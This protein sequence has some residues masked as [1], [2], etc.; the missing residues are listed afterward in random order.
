MS[1]STFEVIQSELASRKEDIKPS[2]V[3]LFS[4]PLRSAINFAVRLGNFSLTAFSK[5]L[6]LTRAESKQIADILVER[7][8]FTVQPN[9]TDEEIFYKARL[10][11]PARSVFDRKP[12][13]I[14]KKIE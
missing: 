8:L 3:I 9:S 6:G 13:D 7:H 11:A 5:K 4:E 1:E 14:L 2:D 10:S 12:S